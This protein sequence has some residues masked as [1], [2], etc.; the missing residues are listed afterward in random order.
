MIAHLRG[1]VAARQAGTVVV[2]VGGVGYLVHVADPGT[3]PP[4]G[5]PVE[6]H[7]YLQVREDAL[8]LYGFPDPDGRELFEQLMSA[9]GVGPKLALA[10]LRTHRPAILRRA[11]A[12]GDL[13]TLKA[14]PGIGRKSAER[15]V[16]E[17]KDK[18]AEQVAAGTAAPDGAGPAGGAR[19]QLMREVAEALSS[20]GYSAG[21]IQEALAAVQRSGGEGDREGGEDPGVAALVRRALRELGSS[22]AGSRP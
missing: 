1:Q 9:S 10:A 18:L 3:V 11:I 13:E 7:T 2:D 15:L 16:V 22:P 14:V 6:L 5:Q 4:R 19:S 8:E 21:E 20:L 17:L 12:G